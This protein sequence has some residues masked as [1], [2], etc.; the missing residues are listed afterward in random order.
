MDEVC[1]FILTG[2]NDCPTAIRE[3]ALELML[4]SRAQCPIA[5]LEEI[6]VE[7]KAGRKISAIKLIRTLTG[8]GLVASKHLAED[9]LGA[10][11]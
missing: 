9:F 11:P 1:R 10:R 7:L 2:C 4:L 5:A 6:A 3:T 8:A